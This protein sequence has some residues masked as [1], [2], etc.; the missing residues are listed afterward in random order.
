MLFPLHLCI[1]GYVFI[2]LR[3]CINPD[4]PSTKKFIISRDVQ[5][6]E[7][8]YWDGSLEKM[9][10]V[11][12]CV[13]HEEEEEGETSNH[14]SMVAPPPPPQAQ[15]TTPQAGNRTTLRDQ[16]SSSPSTP[17]GSKLPLV[18]VELQAHQQDQNSEI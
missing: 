6:I 13:S 17:H 3:S 15:K 12:T 4:H 1:Y 10:N 11:K 16:G 7:E 9:V 2:L 14:P 18:Q 5:F 8:E